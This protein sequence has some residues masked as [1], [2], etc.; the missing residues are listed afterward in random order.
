MDPS[1]WCLAINYIKYWSSI[2]SLQQDVESTLELDYE[3]VST[4]M[5]PNGPC[6][7]LIYLVGMDYEGQIGFKFTFVHKGVSIITQGFIRLSEQSLW[8]GLIDS[9]VGLIGL[10]NQLGPILGQIK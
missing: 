6:S 1:T 5:G 4:P 9:L 2:E 8:I 3:E 7:E 10:I